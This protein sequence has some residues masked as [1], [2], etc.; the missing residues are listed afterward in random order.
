MFPA[1]PPIAEQGM[2][3]REY[4]ALRVKTKLFSLASLSIASNSRQLKLA[5]WKFI[6]NAPQKIVFRIW[7]QF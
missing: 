5:L 7:I 1:L 3:G 4:G 6:H 2:G